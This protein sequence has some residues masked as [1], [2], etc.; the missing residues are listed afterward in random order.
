MDARDTLDLEFTIENNLEHLLNLNKTVHNR[1][2]QLYPN[3]FKPYNTETFRPWFKEF[4][5]GKNTI[6]VFVKNKGEYIGYALIVHRKALANNPFTNPDFESLYVDQM[7]IGEAYQNRGVGKQLIEYIKTIAKERGINKIQ[8]DVW[9][10][11]HQ[12]KAFYEKSQFKTIREI[13]E[14]QLD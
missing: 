4:L 11:N 10:N 3:V 8:L 2:H 9:N 6:C 1:H 5:K 12:A 13:M 14:L 7:S